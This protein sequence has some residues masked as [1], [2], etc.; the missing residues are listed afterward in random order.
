L[1]NLTHKSGSPWFN[2]YHGNQPERNG[3]INRI[4]IKEWFDDLAD[5]A[6]KDSQDDF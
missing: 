1:I 6:D 3:R 2:V 4:N 5:D